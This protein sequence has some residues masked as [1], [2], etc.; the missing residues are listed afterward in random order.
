MYVLTDIKLVS[1]LENPNCPIQ[2]AAIRVNEDWDTVDTFSAAIGSKDCP[3]QQEDDLHPS[4][5]CGTDAAPSGET[6]KVLHAFQAWRVPDDVPC[7]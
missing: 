7:W 4:C 5:C 3:I 6:R 2:L 1:T